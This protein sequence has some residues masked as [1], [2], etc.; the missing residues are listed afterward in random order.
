MMMIDDEDDDC[1]KLNSPWS[2]NMLLIR[3]VH[4]C[5]KGNFVFGR[6]QTVF[7]V[8]HRDDVIVLGNSRPE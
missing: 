5:L 7:W 2:L 4:F 8:G 1:L 3:L 6:K